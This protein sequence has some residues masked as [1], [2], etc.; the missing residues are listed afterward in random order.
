MEDEYKQHTREEI[1]KIAK[2]D[3]E[4]FVAIC[5][6]YLTQDNERYLATIK[7]LLIEMINSID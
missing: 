2:R 6:Y 1:M 3:E 5:N 4:R 7:P